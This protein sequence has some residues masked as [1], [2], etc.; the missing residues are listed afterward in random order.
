MVPE[1]EESK[2]MRSVPLHKHTPKK[3]NTTAHYSFIAYFFKHVTQLPHK[4]KCKEKCK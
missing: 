3:I 1:R 2:K 4:K